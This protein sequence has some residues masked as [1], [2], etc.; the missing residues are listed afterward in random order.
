M[1]N[2]YQKMRLR[3]LAFL[4]FFGK[5]FLQPLFLSAKIRVF[6]RLSVDSRQKRIESM[7]LRTKNVLPWMGPLSGRETKNALLP[8]LSL[9]VFC[10]SNYL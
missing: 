10:P 8:P 5:R 9:S 2:G 1:E 4:G 3:S 6:D 7:R